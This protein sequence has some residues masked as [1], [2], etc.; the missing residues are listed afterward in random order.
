MDKKITNTKMKLL[1]IFTIC[2]TV[3]MMFNIDAMR[4]SHLIA[5]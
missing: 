2:S 3:F 1:K 5:E 4:I